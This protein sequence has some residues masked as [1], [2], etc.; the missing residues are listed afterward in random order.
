[1]SFLQIGFRLHSTMKLNLPKFN[2]SSTPSSMIQEVLWHSCPCTPDPMKI[3]LKS[4]I[5]RFGQ[6]RNKE[7]MGFELLTLKPFSRLF[8]SSHTSIMFV[9]TYRMNG[10]LYGS[11]WAW[12][13]HYFPI[14]VK[15]L[16]KRMRA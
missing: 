11:K 15:F 2:T 3:F 10:S 9:L 7:K 8:R 12:I 14:T 1:M 4:Q 13:C 6:S 5:G 16:G